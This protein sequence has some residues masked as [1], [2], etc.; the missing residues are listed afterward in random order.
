MRL[1]QLGFL[2]QDV[3]ARHRVVLHE[4]EFVGGGALVFGSGVEVPGSGRGFELDF[5]TGAF[6]HDGSPVNLA[7]G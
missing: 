7:G 6:G 3:L 4:L 1:L 5:F 2:V